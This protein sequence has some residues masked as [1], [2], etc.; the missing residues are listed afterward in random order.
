MIKEMKTKREHIFAQNKPQF[1]SRKAERGNALIYVL[2]AIALFAALSFTLS[3]Q[4]DSNEASVLSDEKAELYAT[5]L[6]SYA[7][8]AKSAVDQML[9]S[10]ASIDDLDFTLP[11]EPGFDTGQVIYKVYHPQGGGLTPGILPEEVINEVNSNPEAGWYMGRFNNFE[12]TESTDQEIVLTAYQIDQKVCALINQKINGT[13]NIPI[14]PDVRAH[15]IASGFIPFANSDLRTNP[16]GSPECLD[17]HNI[18]SLC[19][20]NATLADRYSFYTIIADQ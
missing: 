8:Q 4:T 18:S 14:M 15:L 5:Q 12:W 7:A 11:S 16:T 20:I 19:V 6:I 13:Q 9:F 10:G 3:R 17:C 1:K 2:I